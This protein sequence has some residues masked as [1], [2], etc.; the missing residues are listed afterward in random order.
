[1]R[2][3]IRLA[4]VCAAFCAFLAAPASAAG[5]NDIYAAAGVR[6]D[7]SAAN[8]Q[9]ARQAAVAA[10]Q[11][12][13]FERLV[14]RVAS[15]QDL[16]RLGIPR[17]DQPTLDRMVSGIDVADERRSST[18][19]I[20]N[21]AVN[22]DSAAVRAYLQQAGFSLV[23]TRAPGVLLIPLMVN[24]PPGAGEAWR[25]A[26][27][28]GGFGQEL[29]PVSVVAAATVASLTG[30]VDWPQVQD[31]ARTAGAATA[32]FATLRAAE[33]FLVADLVE[34]GPGTPP[35]AR[36]QISTPVSASEASFGPAFD[37]LAASVVGRLQNDWKQS[38]AGGAGQRT[39]ITIVA[40]YE[41]PAQ[42]AQIKKALS[43]AS[44]TIVSDVQVDGLAKEG[45]LISFSYIGTRDQLA[46]EF[47]R[48]GVDAAGDGATMILRVRG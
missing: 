11:R 21:L 15:D 24:A 5:R 1:M 4:A 42:W 29:L 43:A 16:A 41:T 18:R 33:G 32:I 45:A 23:E 6:A 17:V 26:F 31:A 25:Q 46:A 20:A 39:R 9:V 28:R 38:L 47:G 36:G 27:D 8:A 48:S 3:L 19:Y 30:Q 37:R 2:V 40:R 10:A 14:R 35:R 13:A 22:F 34:I 7:A 12:T 44:S